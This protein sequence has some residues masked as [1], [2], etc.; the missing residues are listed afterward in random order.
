MDLFAGYAMTDVLAIDIATTTGWTRGIVGQQPTCGSIRFG[1]GT[2][3]NNVIFGRAL[4]WISETL[5]P[6]PRPDILILEAM[7]PPTAMVNHTSRAVRDRLA[8]LHGVFRGVAYLRGIGEIAE[9]T[10]G[11]VRAHFI[12][13]RSAK[14]DDAK[15]LTTQRCQRLGWQVADDNAADAAALWSFACALIDPK[16]A[17]QVVPLFNRRLVG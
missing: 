7:L 14:R 9:A 16:S 1:G 12:G 17:M 15:R 6:K 5:E 11:D 8:G 3:V 4:R 13:D 10:V 2:D